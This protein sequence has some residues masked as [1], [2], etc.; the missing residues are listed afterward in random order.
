MAD[1]Q[2]LLK[3]S[4]AR[5]RQLVGSLGH[6]QL[7]AQAYPSEWTVADVLSHRGSGAVI[8]SL[9]IDQ[10]LGGDEVVPQ[11]IWDEWNAKDPEAKASDCL[12]ADQAFLERLD[13]LTDEE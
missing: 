9:R 8:S 5:L 4:I 12:R 10:A 1:E 2:V 7:R 3:A 13:A 6:D 11:P